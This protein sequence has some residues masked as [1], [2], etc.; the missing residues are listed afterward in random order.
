MQ[1]AELIQQGRR[2]VGLLVGADA[3]DRALGRQAVQHL[4][5]AVER[6][7]VAGDARPIEVDEAVGEAGKAG[8]VQVCAGLAEA[9]LQHGAHARTDEVAGRLHRGRAQALRHQHDVQ[10]ADEVGRRVDQRAVQVEGEGHA[11]EAAGRID[12][13]GHGQARVVMQVVI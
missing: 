2:Q 1:Q 5:H 8:L 9:V 12:G 10:R 7:A 6:A 3:E 4:G 11:A 13:R